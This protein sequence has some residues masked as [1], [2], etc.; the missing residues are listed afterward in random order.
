MDTLELAN[1]TADPIQVV[2]MSFYFDPFTV[3]LAKQ[4]GLHRFQFYG[5]G[6]GGVL[7]D[8]DRQTVDEAFTFFNPSVYDFLWDGAR[9]KAD[10]VETA[11]AYVQAAYE[12]ADR[13]F[14]AIARDVLAAY[15]QAAHKVVAHV[16]VGRHHLVD[17][18]RQ[19]PIPSDPVHAAYLGAIL[20]RE[21]RGGVHIV[22]VRE[23]GL[24]ALEAC[25]LQN[26]DVFRSHG[27]RDDDAPEVTAEHE[28]KKIEAERLTNLMMANC[29]SVL[30]DDERQAL[31]AGAL[32]MYDA[33]TNPGAAVA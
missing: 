6:R 20:M 32:A 10:P 29:F 4:R 28:G 21:L 26:P 17:G 23:A 11:A 1:V 15:A 18:Y 27:Y 14:G 22:A 24:S 9:E 2:G 13:T 19:Y 25:Y 12:Y 7:G 31:R 16:E 30:S 8:V 5:L 3:E 33:I